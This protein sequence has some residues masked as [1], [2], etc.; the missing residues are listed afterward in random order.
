MKSHKCLQQHSQTYNPSV[1]EMYS[2]CMHSAI[3][4]FGVQ[5]LLITWTIGLCHELYSFWA[6]SFPWV[7][8]RFTGTASRAKIICFLVVRVVLVARLPWQ[9]SDTSEQNYCSHSTVLFDARFAFCVRSVQLSTGAA[10]RNQVDVC[11]IQTCII[12]KSQVT[13]TRNR[14]FQRR[15]RKLP[16][17]KQKRQSRRLQPAVA[18]VCMTA[19]QRPPV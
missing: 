10:K 11:K 6:A 19:C 5:T 7:K 2:S 4:W 3:D 15:Q 9:L 17:F 1:F 18:F 14:A 16:E 8:N 12:Q 13:C